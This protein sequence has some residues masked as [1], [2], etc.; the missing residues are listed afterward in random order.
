MSDAV[1]PVEGGGLG[2]LTRGSTQTETIDSLDSFLSND[3]V[4]EEI[5]EEEEE[6]E[7]IYKD[8]DELEEEVEEESEEE[9]EDEEPE[10]EDSDEYY[11][12]NIE[13][14]D[15]EVT[16]DEL[17]TGYRRHKDHTK[18]LAE[19]KEQ[20]EGFD[21]KMKEAVAKAEHLDS[22]L[23]HIEEQDNLVLKEFDN[24][25]WDDLRIRNPNQ[26]AVQRLKYI[27]AQE[28]INEKAN[29]RKDLKDGI[30]SEANRNRDTLKLSE[31]KRIELE[32]GDVTNDK[33]FIDRIS[34]Q[35]KTEGF[36][37]IDT[38]LLDHAV[39]IKLLDKASKY[40][41][42]QGKRKGAKEKIRKVVSKTTKA[43]SQRSKTPK[44]K[45]KRA[46]A[47]T[48]AQYRKTGTMSDAGLMFEQ[49]V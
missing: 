33:D 10:E 40:D 12:V 47:E 39:V 6:V 20:S 25:N 26:Y 9:I 23:A 42:L 21:E 14:E 3:P 32:Y 46:T 41:E 2:L 45:S 15:Y 13:G 1:T 36:E 4:E 48:I 30:S 28:L 34:A 29:L 22:I 31:L 43:G 5:V 7:D 19:V 49:F 11:V 17:V 37:D 18:A 16:Q 24:V 8:E 44:A 35:V 38:S 27:E